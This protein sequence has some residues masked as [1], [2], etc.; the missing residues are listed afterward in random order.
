MSAFAD[1]AG[2]LAGYHIAVLA[3][4]GGLVISVIAAA[5][6]RKIA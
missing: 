2:A 4:G 5:G 1:A 3:L 6:R